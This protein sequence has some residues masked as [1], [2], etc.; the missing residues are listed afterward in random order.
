MELTN[1]NIGII[2]EDC[3]T[4]LN[5]CK[6]SAEDAETF[7]DT[8]SEILNLYRDSLGEESTIR[9]HVR[10]RSGRTELRF[11]V[12]GKKHDIFEEG[13]GA[14]ERRKLKTVDRVLFDQKSALTYR[15]TSGYNIV[16]VRSG[17]KR[18]SSNMLKQPMIQAVI[19]GLV[20]GLICL[21]LPEAANAFIV[22]EVTEPVLTVALA[23]LSG[24]LGPI[25]FLSIVRAVSAL[26]SLDEFTGL[27]SKVLKR[28]LIT[29]L[30]IAVFSDILGVIFFPFFGRRD[31]AFDPGKLIEISLDVIPTS[32]VTPFVENNI[33][34]IVILGIGMGAVLLRLG[35]RAKGL[36][37][38]LS[39]IFEWLAGLMETIK[40]ILPIVPFL[41]VFNI[42]ARGE[43]AIFLRGWKYIVATYICMALCVLFKIFKVNKKCSID[44]PVIWSKIK[45]V[46]RS[47]LLAGSSRSQSSY[48]TEISEKELGIDRDYTSFWVPMSDGMLDPSL[49]ISFV[50]APF[51]VAD[52]TGTPVS[53]SFLLI[54]MLLAVEL[55]MASPGLTAGYTLIFQSLGMSADYVGMF[56]VFSIVIKNCAAACGAAYKILEHIESAYVTEHIDMS[57]FNKPIR[58]TT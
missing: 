3:R 6:L 1:S 32:F 30:C 15:Y 42:V 46:V 13:D 44:I 17:K 51:L 28:F 33:P 9:Y 54:L 34:Q 49:T 53:F 50:L 7:I 35:D 26:D 11:G 19:G 18:T 39:Q 31:I 56:S 5:K 48:I 45:P 4:T 23:V 55:S 57:V 37:D 16:T 14:E 21:Q 25:V 20:A 8:A 29:T 12:K 38:L 52:I 24:L 47:C 43:T 58:Q 36:S 22:N 2:I 27:G 10:K 40:V 41:S